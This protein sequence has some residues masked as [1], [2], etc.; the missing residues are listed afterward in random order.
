VY[1]DKRYT[2]ACTA[3]LTSTVHFGKKI[4]ADTAV[5]RQMEK[6]SR[7]FSTSYHLGGP[8]VARD[9]ALL[10]SYRAEHTT[11][12]RGAFAVTERFLSG[13]ALST[14]GAAVPAC[15]QPVVARA[16]AGAVKSVDVLLA[17]AME[18]LGWDAALRLHCELPLVFDK[19]SLRAVMARLRLQPL[20]IN[21]EKE[22]LVDLTGSLAGHDLSAHRDALMAAMLP[23]EGAPARST[24][25][26]DDPELGGRGRGSAVDRAWAALRDAAASLAGAG[27]EPTLATVRAAMDPELHPDVRRKPR[28]LRT[29]A[30]AEAR[31]LEGLSAAMRVLAPER[32]P[33]PAAAAAAEAAAAARAAELRAIADA[34]PEAPDGSIVS[35]TMSTSVPQPLGTSKRV[36]NGDHLVVKGTMVGLRGRLHNDPAAGVST[37][38]GSGALPPPGLGQ[39]ANECFD[40]GVNLFAAGKGGSGGGSGGGGSS[41]SS[42]S[43]SG[44]PLL[45]ESA[46]FEQLPGDTPLPF[47]AFRFWCRHLSA[48]TPSDDAFCRVMGTLFHVGVTPVVPESYPPPRTEGVNVPDRNR[49][50]KTAYAEVGAGLAFATIPYDPTLRSQPP[51]QPPPFSDPDF[52][53]SQGA[54]PAVALLVTHSDGRQSLQRVRVNRFTHSDDGAAGNLTALLQALHMAGVT[55]AVSCTVDF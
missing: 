39:T 24:A 33:L 23:G 25:G 8:A 46:M 30:S 27:A 32:Y 55:D 7:V 3:T 4:P 1:P 47:S 5:G 21:E 6:D 53:F 22:L 2:N 26:Q 20:T 49:G 16:R 43:S 15:Y 44:D 18:K 17:R 36:A 40:W 31:A 37:G 45:K 10:A 12:V 11:E 34:A 28:P 35:R 19:L 14:G 52:K 48:A 9:A 13:A 42:S 50:E 29:P 41:G 51:P 54:A 38:G